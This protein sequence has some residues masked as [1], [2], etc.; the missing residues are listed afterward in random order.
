[1]SEPNNSSS[2]FSVPV[3]SVDAASRLIG[4]LFDV[5]RADAVY[6]KPQTQGETT[7]IVASEVTVGMGVGFG[8]GEGNRADENSGGNTSPEE[9]MRCLHLP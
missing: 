4:R 7:V 1:M 9:L 6:S 2:L 5:A 3:R 8:G